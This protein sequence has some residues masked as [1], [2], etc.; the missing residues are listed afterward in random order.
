MGKMKLVASTSHCP[1]LHDLRGPR[2][3][4]AKGNCTALIRTQYKPIHGQ[5]YTGTRYKL[6][7]GGLQDLSGR[8]DEPRLG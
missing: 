3:D 2:C 4:R 7:A 5:E 8:A 6:A 1:S